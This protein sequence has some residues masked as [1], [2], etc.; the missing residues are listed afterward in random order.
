MNPPVPEV[1]Q[2]PVV[3]PPETIPARVTVELFP[4]TVWSIPAFTIIGAV[5]T[6]FFNATLLKHPA[7]EVAVT[8]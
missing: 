1:V 3:V 2:I 8:V 6:T 5:T 4:Q 7:A